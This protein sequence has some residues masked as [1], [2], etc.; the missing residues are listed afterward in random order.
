[1]FRYM[2]E[3]VKNTLLRSLGLVSIDGSARGWFLLRVLMTHDR[4]PTWTS[5]SKLEIGV[6][7]MVCHT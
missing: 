6:G 7:M 3:Y 1:M 4:Y 2:L 5:S